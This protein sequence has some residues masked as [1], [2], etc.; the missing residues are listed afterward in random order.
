MY[1]RHCKESINDIFLDLGHAPPSNAY[2]SKDNLDKEERYLPLQ[3]FVCR[4]C[5]LVQT[6]DCFNANELFTKEYAYLSSASTSWLKHCKEYS[7]EVI[8]KF[9]LNKESLV[10][11]VA[12]NDG[13][14]LKNFKSK[15]I[16]CFGIEPTDST[17][18]RARELGLQIISEFCTEKTS[19]RIAQEYGK[20]DL[21]IAN[22]VYA[23]V[24]D[25]NDFTLGIKNLMKPEGCIS[26]EFPHLL[27]LIKYNQFD[28]IYHEHYSYLSLIAV[29]NIFKRFNLRIWKAE[30]IP[31]HG[32]SLRIYVCSI[33]SQYKEDGSLEKILKEEEKF[34]LRDI[35]TYS[36]FQIKANKIKHDLLLLLINLKYSNKKVVAYGAAAKGNTLLNYAGIKS[37]LVQCV[38]DSAESKQF[39]FLPGSHIPILPQKD[40]F[41]FNPDYILILPWNISEEIMNQLSKLKERG[42]KFITAIPDI[43]II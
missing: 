22:N 32:G 15:E 37:D 30:K 26:I 38:F 23:H 13:Y 7:L 1:C 4:N 31:T 9:N 33:S 42:A 28:T 36:N 27:N 14:M 6:N 20:A 18:F 43:K 40:I 21:V 2:I 16:P 10:T 8:N 3:V 35:K 25:I 19:L 12:S 29:N 5:W 34:G 41:K 24:P 39:M 17:A 11:E